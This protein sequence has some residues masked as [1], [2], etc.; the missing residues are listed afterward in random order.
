MWISTCL[1]RRQEGKKWDRRRKPRGVSLCVHTLRRGLVFPP[2]PINLYVGPEH[3]CLSDEC[4]VTFRWHLLGR[5]LGSAAHSATSSQTW[6]VPGP[7]AHQQVSMHTSPAG[8]EGENQ[9][10][11]CR[12]GCSWAWVSPHACFRVARAGCFLRGLENDRIT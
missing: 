1:I 10:A 6:C 5:H 9:P 7:C 11:G 12:V 4:E 3:S 8:S 2:A